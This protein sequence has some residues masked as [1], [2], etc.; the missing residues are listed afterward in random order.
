MTKRNLVSLRVIEEGK[1]DLLARGRRGGRC[2][3]FDVF[4]FSWWLPI[5]AMMSYRELEIWARRKVKSQGSEWMGS[6]EA[7]LGTLEQPS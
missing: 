4:H 1:A 3:D 7:N 5:Q 6:A 2:L